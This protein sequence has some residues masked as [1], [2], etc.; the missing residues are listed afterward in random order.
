ME[1]ST[2]A[3]G[4]FFIYSA[5]FFPCQLHFS[6]FNI[7]PII[8]A[9][10]H[11][12]IRGEILIM[13]RGGLSLSAGARV[14]S[15]CTNICPLRCNEYYSSIFVCRR[16]TCT[17]II[18]RPG[19]VHRSCT[20]FHSLFVLLLKPCILTRQHFCRYLV[21]QTACYKK[22]ETNLND[23]TPNNTHVLSLAKTLINSLFFFHYFPFQRPLTS[24]AR[25]GCGLYSLVKLN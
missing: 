8:M 22:Q 9:S 19:R 3:S 13:I 20:K 17:N 25:S 7:I 5:P 2:F 11:A 15:T 10:P 16:Q 14:E 18:R 4:M 6:Q 12:L 24:T 1:V 23:V 21:V